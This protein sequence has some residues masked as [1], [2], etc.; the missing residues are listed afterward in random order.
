[1]QTS[2][3]LQLHLK[4]K[5][6]ELRPMFYRWKNVLLGHQPLQTFQCCHQ[7]HRWPMIVKGGGLMSKASSSYKLALFPVNVMYVIKRRSEEIWGDLCKQ[8]VTMHVHVHSGKTLQWPQIQKFRWWPGAKTL[9]SHIHV[10]V[11]TIYFN[12]RK[13]GGS[14][15]SSWPPL[16]QTVAV[17]HPQEVSFFFSASG[18]FS[19]CLQYI[20][21]PF[22]DHVNKNLF[23]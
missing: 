16:D 13:S 6:P 12:H 4:Y 23:H 15:H 9:A 10:H 20:K 1:M 19:S 14:A 22:L 3:I 2:W 8:R 5:D 17:K 11:G 21:L 18:F 7:L